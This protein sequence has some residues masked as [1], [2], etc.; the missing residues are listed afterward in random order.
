MNNCSF[1]GRLTATPTL[2]QTPNGKS[3]CNFTLAVDKRFSNANGEKEVFYIDMIAWNS[4]SEF[5]CRWFD[6]GVRVAVTGELQTRMYEDKDGKKVKVAEVLVSTVEFADGKREANENV[7][8]GSR[9]KTDATNQASDDVFKS[10][11]FGNDGFVPLGN[12]DSLPF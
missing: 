1:V 12:D 3:V 8:A 7:S 5:L 11:V 6:K 10:D 2:K 9:E 4:Q